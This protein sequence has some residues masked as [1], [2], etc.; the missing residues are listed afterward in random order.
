MTTF[1][2]GPVS[3][4][5]RNEVVLREGTSDQ[6]DAG[7]RHLRGSNFIE[8]STLLTARQRILGV[9]ASAQGEPVVAGMAAS[10]L[11]GSAWYDDDFTIELV[12]PANG[13]GRPAKG[14]ITHRFDID[15][16]DWCVVDGVRVTTPLRTA[17]DIG[18]MQ[19]AWLALGYLDSL[20]RATDL[21]NLAV[22]RYADAQRRR[23]HVRQ[24]RE[25]ASL[26]DD[27]AESPPESWVRLLMFRSEL[28]TPDLQIVVTDRS[29][30]PFARID[31]GYEALKIGVEYDGE[32]FHSSPEQSARDEARDASLRE[33]GWIMIR[34]DR[35][36]LRDEP[37][38]IIVEIIKAM[39][40]RGAY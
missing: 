40:A 28:P 19:P 13:S 9:A 3:L 12:R 4:T 37:F 23:R 38:G 8:R 20:A 7:F 22:A 31:L 25:L 26:I 15:P 16:S 33:Q 2:T 27:R 1:E 32:D 5:T 6:F 10:I 17:F 39:K 14:T 35:R 24:I 18:R 36:R 30:N 11:L 21:D 34:V 29:G